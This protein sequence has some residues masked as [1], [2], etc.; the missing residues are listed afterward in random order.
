MEGVLRVSPPAPS[1]RGV[2]E[3]G[4][5]GWKPE[6]C[7]D[8]HQLDGVQ[9]VNTNPWQTSPRRGRPITLVASR[10]PMMPKGGLV[11]QPHL[12]VFKLLCISQHL[13]LPALAVANSKHLLLPAPAGPSGKPLG[14]CQCWL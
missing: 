6:M 14:C 2:G 13:L 10:G 8:G 7:A 1:G 3:S 11:V 4:N 9:V 5:Q 12:W